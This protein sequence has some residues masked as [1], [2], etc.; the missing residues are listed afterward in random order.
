MKRPTPFDVCDAVRLYAK[1]G[2]VAETARRLRVHT[3]R[4]RDALL[5]AGVDVRGAR[6]MQR[7]RVAE[8]RE[9]I[10]KLHPIL[11][12]ARACAAVLGCTE[13]TALRDA[14]ALGFKWDRPVAVVKRPTRPR[15]RA[16]KR[17]KHP[18]PPKPPKAR[19]T[20][21]RWDDG[22]PDEDDISWATA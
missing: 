12:S 18:R 22:L 14:N 17:V 15:V 1:I 7:Q 11:G 21:R 13:S 4:V 9:I 3:T 8:R 20:P 5:D 19:P 10:A 16:A 2:S 6:V